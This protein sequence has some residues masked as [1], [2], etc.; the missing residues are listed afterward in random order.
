M[1]YRVV[2]TT[3]STHASTVEAPTADKAR[4]LWAQGYE[5]DDQETDAGT[6]RILRIERMA[7]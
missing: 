1:I 2:Y 3:T 7:S 5:Q 4:L 6:C